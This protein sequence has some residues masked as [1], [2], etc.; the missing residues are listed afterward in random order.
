MWPGMEAP[1]ELTGQ[2]HYVSTRRPFPSGGIV[3]SRSKTLE[4]LSADGG[5]CEKV[6]LEF[7]EAGV[8]D[9]ALA[10]RLQDEG[11]KSFVQSWTDLMEVIASK[12]AAL[13]EATI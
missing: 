3:V 12:S 13:K 7:T 6:L 5:E 9:H 10:E 4:I 8:D 2:G 11:A 1:K